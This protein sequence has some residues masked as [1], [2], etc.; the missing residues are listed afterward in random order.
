MSK[1]ESVPWLCQITHSIAQENPAI[2]ETSKQFV[3]RWVAHLDSN[4]LTLL[5]RHVDANPTA[6]VHHRNIEANF[7]AVALVVHRFY[8]T[9]S[10]IARQTGP[11]NDGESQ[12]SLSPVAVKSTTMFL[13]KG[14]DQDSH[15]LCECG[16]VLSKVRIQPV[17]FFRDVDV[18]EKPV[19]RVVASLN[20]L[21][22]EDSPLKMICKYLTTLV[23]EDTEVTG[24]L[25]EHYRSTIGTMGSTIAGMR[26]PIRLKN[27]RAS[28][29]MHEMA[30]QLPW[31]SCDVTSMCIFTLAAP[32]H[33]LR[34]IVM[35]S[36]L[37]NENPL[38]AGGLYNPGF[39]VELI[40]S[41]SLLESYKYA[42]RAAL[43]SQKTTLLRVKLIDVI[44]S[45]CEQNESFVR[46]L[47]LMSIELQDL[48]PFSHSFLLGVGPEGV[49][50]F[51][52]YMA[53]GPRLHEYIVGGGLRVRNWQEGDDFVSTFDAFAKNDEETFTRRK[54]QLFKKM[55]GLDLLDLT[56]NSKVHASR[57]MP[58]FRAWVD[59]QILE[60]VKT[61]DVLKF[62]WR[63]DETTHENSRPKT[64]GVTLNYH[65]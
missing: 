7:H 12:L 21:S 58:Y 56:A 63:T 45:Y 55:F 17:A 43:E 59:V 46:A 53:F 19:Q 40:P 61:S 3:E 8:A 10:M 41:A 62:D 13:E 54:N 18:D 36:T 1:L 5:Q 60:D 64:D 9:K 38:L 26:V 30:C 34:A 51:Q 2:P 50:M 11:A 48:V 15:G 4:Q 27:T 6:E 25:L 42:K 23:S 47:N 52:S 35:E 14:R 33:D 28:D 20:C 65:M 31:H 37:G 44:Q 39:Q 22:P 24:F 32:V 16:L 49:V 57:M 29:F